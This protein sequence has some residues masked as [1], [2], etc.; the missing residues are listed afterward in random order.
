MK[1][2]IIIVHNNINF[3]FDFIIFFL[4]INNIQYFIKYINVILSPIVHIFAFSI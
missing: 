2:S 4:F 3:S 1:H